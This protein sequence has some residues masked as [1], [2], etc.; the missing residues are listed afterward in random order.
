MIWREWVNKILSTTQKRDNR[1]RNRRLNRRLSIIFHRS[2][3]N[4][5]LRG[6]EYWIIFLLLMSSI[7][8]NNNLDVA[9]LANQI[10]PN[11]SSDP[12]KTLSST[13]TSTSVK[14]PKTLN[15]QPET[16]H[17]QWCLQSLSFRLLIILNMILRR[18]YR[19]RGCDRIWVWGCLCQQYGI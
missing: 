1:G 17:L 19:K 18:L 2:W 14:N 9:Y 11:P 16:T 12:N 3:H 15:F 13:P 8:L 5:C 6:R 10:P 4:M 7:Y